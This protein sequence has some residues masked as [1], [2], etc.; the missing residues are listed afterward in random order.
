MS[1]IS[2]YSRGNIFFLNKLCN[3]CGLLKSSLTQMS[4]RS[5]STLVFL[6]HLWA[7]RS[8]SQSYCSRDAVI[9]TSIIYFS[10]PF[11]PHTVFYLVPYLSILFSHGCIVI[12]YSTHIYFWISYTLLI[13]ARHEWPAW[14]CIWFP[15]LLPNLKFYL[16]ARMIKFHNNV[17]QLTRDNAMTLRDVFHCWRMDLLPT[18]HTPTHYSSMSWEQFLLAHIFKIHMRWQLFLI[19]KQWR[20]LVLLFSPPFSPFIW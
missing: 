18:Y 16:Y 17:F 20:K 10:R 12:L 15:S 4:S 19:Q 9:A 1:S 7:F 8:R 14:S 3:F 5:F 6:I 11:K 2:M 13:C